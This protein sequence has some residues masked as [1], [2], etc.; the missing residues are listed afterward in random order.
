MQGGGREGGTNTNLTVLVDKKEV[1][2]V[3]IHRENV[4]TL[5][6]G[7][8]RSLTCEDDSSVS[9]HEGVVG[10]ICRT[11]LTDDG[12]TETLELAHANYRGEVRGTAVIA[13]GE[14][15]C[16]GCTTGVANGERD[17][18]GGGDRVDDVE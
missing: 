16:A 1:G 12:G 6:S 17:A 5:K 10:I 15:D 4:G 13:I 11:N 9:R 7:V 3:V 8:I 14:L 18:A 2:S